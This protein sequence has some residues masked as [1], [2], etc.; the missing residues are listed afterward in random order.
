MKARI[1]LQTQIHHRDFNKEALHPIFE[2]CIDGE[3]SLVKMENNLFSH[4]RNLEEMFPF[5]DDFHFVKK[6]GLTGNTKDFNWYD[7]EG[8]VVWEEIGDLTSW[9]FEQGKVEA[10]QMKIPAIEFALNQ[11]DFIVK[12]TVQSKQ[13]K[14]D[15]KKKAQIFT[16]FLN[17]LLPESSQHPYPY[18]E[19]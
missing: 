16:Y 15:T 1:V 9:N 6:Q 11:M 4:L 14:N 17:K 5:C 3:T 19:E 18:L 13:A 12:H 10:S 7:L 2:S 8:E